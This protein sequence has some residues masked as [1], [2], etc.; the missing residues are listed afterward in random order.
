M[1]RTL[2]AGAI[3]GAG[4]VSG[5]LLIQSGAWREARAAPATPRLLGQVVARL[6][7]DYIDT[8]SIDD[9]YRR[10]AFGFVKVLEDPRGALLTPERQRRLNETA[11]ARHAGVGI[12]PG[13][14][15]GFVTVIAPL[16]GTPADSAGIEPGDRIILVDSKPTLGLAI[17]EV[18]QL[19]R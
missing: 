13:L 19:L 6:S 17:E 7:R 9:M 3:L 10:A 18:E 16:A 2:I 8:I 11:N 14:R 4:L 12:E 5:G 15:D 1:S